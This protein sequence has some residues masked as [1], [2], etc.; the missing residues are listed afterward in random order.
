MA[1]RLNDFFVSRRGSVTAVAQEV[2]VILR[3]NGYTVLVQDYDFPHGGDFVDK[4]HVAIKNSRDLIVLLS[5]DYEESYWTRKE[6]ASFMADI[7]Q[8]LQERRVIVLRCEEVPVRGLLAPLAYRDLVGVTDPEERK[9]RILDAAEG[10]SVAAPPPRPFVGVPPRIAYFAGRAAALDR[11][12]S[13]LTGGS[14]PAAITQASVGRVAVQGMG[15]IGKTS[16]AIEYAHRFRGLYAGIWWCPAETRTGLLTSL[17]VLGAALEVV[18]RTEADIDKAAQAALRH[19]S[20]QRSTWL[21]VYDNVTAPDSIADLLPSTGVRVLITSRFSDWA[22]CAEEVNLDVLAPEEAVY[23]LQKRAVR[24]DETGA[25]ILA[26]ALGYLPLAL[27]HAAAYCRRTGTRFADYAEEAGTLISAAPR[28]AV[29]P[30]SVVA[31]FNLAIAAAAEQCAAAER[32]MAYMVCGAPERIPMALI[33]GAIDDE[34]KRASALTALV[35]V[36]LLHLDPLPDG[37]PAVTVHRGD[38][39]KAPGPTNRLNR[40]ANHSASRRPRHAVYGSLP[41]ES[42]ARTSIDTPSSAAAQEIFC[43]N[44]PVGSGGSFFSERRSSFSKRSRRFSS[45]ASERN[46]ARALLRPIFRDRLDE[47]Q[48]LVDDFSR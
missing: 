33:E 24:T 44:T 38:A 45:A 25:T 19:L 28:G 6:L 12:D 31:T 47:T 8:G 48:D 7:G 5:R 36:S 46:S 43:A 37:T 15:G 1:A 26:E 4:L 39:L 10:R 2:A 21:L 35:E 30:R 42:T 22:G 16:L 29:Y 9:R 14:K 20:E 3:D 32:L 13:I 11:I 41:G 18:P 40:R 27:D 23:F 17:A 34:Q